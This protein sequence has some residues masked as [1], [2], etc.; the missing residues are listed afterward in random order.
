MADNPDSHLPKYINCVTVDSNPQGFITCFIHIYPHVTINIGN[1][2]PSS[3]VPATARVEGRFM[4]PPIIAKSLLKL[5]SIKVREFEDQ[6]GPIDMKDSEGSGN[7]GS[8]PPGVTV[9]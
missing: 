1:P 9:Q 7:P 8:P 3:S 5:L 2:N 6:N 4:I